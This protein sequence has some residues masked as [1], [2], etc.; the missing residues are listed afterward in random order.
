MHKLTTFIAYRRLN[1]SNIAARDLENLTFPQRLAVVGDAHMFAKE[2]KH[3][4]VY[5]IQLAGLQR[6]VIHD[7]QHQ[8]VEIVAKIHNT[9]LADQRSM[10]AAKRLL[11]EYC[12]ISSPER[13]EIA[14]PPP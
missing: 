14:S 5:D 1:R 12:K 3:S 11:E 7:L 2:G 4:R 13:P 6:M 9:Q 8:L 10:E